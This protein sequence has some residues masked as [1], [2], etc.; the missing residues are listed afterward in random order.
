MLAFRRPPPPNV[1]KP[2][3]LKGQRK[4]MP[5]R[6]PLFPARRTSATQ[7]PPKEKKRIGGSLKPS[8]LPVTKPNNGKSPGVNTI[9][10]PIPV[11][12]KNLSRKS[13][14]KKSE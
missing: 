1:P 2:L 13:T 4:V 8:G 9:I 7:T 5:N 12:A 6:R 3:P 10:A 14:A 11:P